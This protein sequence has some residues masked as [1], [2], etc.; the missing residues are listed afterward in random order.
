MRKGF[1]REH[2]T[3]RDFLQGLGLDKR[4]LTLKWK[5]ENKFQ[6]FFPYLIDL[7]VCYTR[8]RHLPSSSCE[9]FEN[10]CRES[11]AVLRSVNDCCPHLFHLLSYLGEMRCKRPALGAVPVRDFHENRRRERHYFFFDWR[12]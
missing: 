2:V 1:D 10:W 8:R 12:T 7:A 4:G 3:E 6:P 5:G 11:R 9:F